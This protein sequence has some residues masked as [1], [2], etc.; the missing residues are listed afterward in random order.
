MHTL[1]VYV[2]A[3]VFYVSLNEICFVALASVRLIFT[4]FQ[5]L[6]HDS[7]HVRHRPSHL[8]QEEM[9]FGGRFSHTIVFAFDTT[10]FAF[11]LMCQI[12]VV[13]I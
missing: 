8:V 9:S 7:S 12:D 5:Q 3:C 6:L 2:R 4:A 13:S 1:Y 11:V 10:V